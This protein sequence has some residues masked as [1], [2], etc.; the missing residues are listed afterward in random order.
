MYNNKME[1]R[2][3]DSSISKVLLGIILFEELLGWKKGRRETKNNKKKKGRKKG[4]KE[5]RIKKKKK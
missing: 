3:S 4:G 1:K 5:K 2:I